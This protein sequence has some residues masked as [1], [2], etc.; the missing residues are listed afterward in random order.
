MQF[1]R[2][3]AQ[4]TERYVG[5]L[6]EGLR[7]RGHEVLVLAG[8][9][10]RRGPQTALGEPVP[11]ELRVA[12]YPSAGWTGV[13]GL[14]AE[15]LLPLLER[16]RPDLVHLANPAHIGVGLIDAA[17]LRGMP[18]VVTIMDYWWLCP[19]HTLAHHSGRIC[20]AD[21]TWRECLRCIG[22]GDP[23][24]ALRAAGR[25]PGVGAAVLAGAYFSRARLRHG[26]DGELARWRHRQELLHGALARADAV[27]FPSAGTRGRLGSRLDPARLHEVPY[28]LEPRW[29]ALRAPRAPTAPGDPARCTLGFA[30]ALAPHKGAHL[31]LQ[32]VRSLDWTRTRV[33]I[34]GGGGDDRY[35]RQLRD[36]ARGSN[37]EFVGRVA[38]A[39]MPAFLRTL[40][41][42]V[43]PSTW[44]ENLPFVVLEAQALGLP[45]L[46]ARID[47]VTEAV[48]EAQLFAV[49]S[50]SDLA[51]R[52]AEWLRDPAGPPPRRPVA[53]ADEMVES[54]LQVYEVARARRA[55]P[56][57]GR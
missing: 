3:Y 16:E 18:T 29:F 52:L 13:R 33:R 24:P 25:L 44:P 22:A 30:G 37:V 27:I 57:R 21:V 7:E 6:G 28:G 20:D 11:H 5:V 51:R 43:L 50:S 45:V 12:H 38:P 39:E 47:G 46:A 14:A 17:S 41:L 23:R 19:K 4:G 53:T 26:G 9:P 36:L 31:L 15:A 55:A 8:D 54:T 2:G 48:P 42:L 40:D 35:L 34:A 10:E 1:A 49:G 56:D 32:A